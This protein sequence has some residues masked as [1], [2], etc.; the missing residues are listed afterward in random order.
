MTRYLTGVACVLFNTVV[1]TLALDAQVS[2][3]GGMA[4][5]VMLVVVNVLLFQAARSIGE[6]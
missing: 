5:G 3:V 1:I 4:L 2:T 6:R